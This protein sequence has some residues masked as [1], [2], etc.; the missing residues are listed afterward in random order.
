MDERVVHNGLYTRQEIPTTTSVSGSQSA[1]PLHVYDYAAVGV[2][3][4]THPQLSLVPQHTLLHST[5]STSDNGSHAYSKP[6]TPSSNYDRTANTFDSLG[7]PSLPVTQTNDYSKLN[8]VQAGSTLDHSQAYSEVGGGEYSQIDDSHKYSK[9]SDMNSKGYS[10]LDMSVSQATS[11]IERPQVTSS[12]EKPQ[13]EVAQPYEEPLSPPTNCTDPEEDVRN[14]PYST[15]A[16]EADSTGYS[17][18]HVFEGCEGGVR[19]VTSTQPSADAA[20]GRVSST[21]AP[22]ESMIENNAYERSGS[23]EVSGAGNAEQDHYEFEQS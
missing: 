8:G 5:A 14:H 7:S 21:E 1:P 16:A 18:L 9:L 3:G 11:S 12:I 6:A 15:V 23:F 13:E 17:K 19:I 10:Q 2:G 20:E 22:R 4:S